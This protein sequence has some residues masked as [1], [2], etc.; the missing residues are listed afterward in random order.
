MTLRAIA[1][2]STLTASAALA[3]GPSFL[4]ISP[5]VIREM[6]QG[7][8]QSTA[9]GRNEV[10][11]IEAL[12]EKALS[13]DAQVSTAALKELKGLGAIA[14]PTFIAALR[15]VLARD[16]AAV[17]KAVAGIGDSKEAAV[18]EAQIDVIRKEARANIEKLSKEDHDTIKKA[19]EYYDKLIP[20]TAKM[21]EAWSLRLAIAEGMGRRPTLMAMW[22]EVAPAGDKQF[23]IDN[24][25]K[26]RQKA[27]SAVGDFLDRTA[28]LS[29]GKAPKD[30]SLRPVWF[31]GM[32]RKIESYNNALFDK[33]L[34]PE[35]VKNFQMVNTYREAIGL[36]PYEVDARLEQAARR[37]SKSMVDR[38]FFAHD[39]PVP[40]NASPGDR[41][42][43]AGYTGGGWGENIA[44]G[45]SAG[46][47]TFWMWFDSPGHHKNMAGGYNAMGV[48]RWQNK[49][50]QSFAGGPRVMLMTEDEKAKIKID[51][52]IVAPDTGKTEPTKRKGA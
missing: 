4:P 9:A 48:G 24:E 35:E 45:P 29:W 49:F 26:L 25:T 2:L 17:E 19:R 5:S 21:N 50:T 30:E 39:S 13:D 37:H 28:D 47:P 7:K 15:Q 31:Y 18:Y 42:K 3:G 51:G 34:D 16:Q 1:I 41:I 36:M 22:R 33:L 6:E 10:A 43:N 27:A 23:T 11:R 52:E 40:N 32:A 14:R 8:G 46:E 20:M 12:K 44:A 38:N